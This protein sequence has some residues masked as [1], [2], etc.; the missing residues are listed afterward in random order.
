MAYDNEEH[1]VLR[2][3]QEVRVINK[4]VPG[5]SAAH[6]EMHSEIRS[7]IT[8]FGMPTFFLTINPADVFNSLVKFLAGSE[9]NIDQLLPEQVPN[10]W[11]QALLIAKNPVIAAK[12]FNIYMK[13]FI[14]TLLAYDSSGKDLEGGVL[15]VVKGYYGCVEA[16][17]RGTLHCHMLIWL[18][19]GLNPDEIKQ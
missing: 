9:I 12:F 17:G 3:M 5:L 10:Y 16:Q 1:Q 6:I 18:E 15:G 4:H 13:A 2:L 19:G 11:E 14:Q 7:M 8:Q